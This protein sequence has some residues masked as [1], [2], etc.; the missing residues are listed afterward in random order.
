M[1]RAIDLLRRRLRADRLIDDGRTVDGRAHD[2]HTDGGLT[3]IEL[4]V[5]SALSLLVL[6]VI[7]SIMISGFTA[8]K[9]VSATNEA[10]SYAQL[11]ARQMQAGIREASFVHIEEGSSSGSQLMVARTETGSSGD[12]ATW[13]CQA[14]FYDDTAGAI[15]HITYPGDSFWPWGS[16]ITNWIDLGSGLLEVVDVGAVLGDTLDWLF[17]GDDDGVAEWSLLA[18]GIRNETGPDDV[19][20]DVFTAAG[21]QGATIA[22]EFDAGDRT[23]IL[24]TTTATGRQAYS[25]SDPQCFSE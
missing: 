21:E 17:G 18:A 5:A 4:I 6:G 9:N 16:D 12:D 23:P 13:E 3:L 14:W 15:F 10:T 19:E 25:E 2:R 20:A 11:A 8:Q 1:R 7:A 24:I 22:F